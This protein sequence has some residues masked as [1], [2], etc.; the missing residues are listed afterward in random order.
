MLSQVANALFGDDQV[1]FE[2][3]DFFTDLLDIS[4][5][6]LENLREIVFFHDFNVS[7]GSA[8]GKKETGNGANFD[9]SETTIS[10]LIIDTF[11]YLIRHDIAHALA[12]FRLTFE[13]NSCH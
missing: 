5:L 9:F 3:N 11:V 12:F 13:I 1:R 4:L 7:L 2:F 6:H 8:V 10:Y